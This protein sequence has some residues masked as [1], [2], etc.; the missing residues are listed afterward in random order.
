[1]CTGNVQ[2]TIYVVE[3]KCAGMELA[4]EPAGRQPSATQQR[5]AAA[6]AAALPAE[7]LPA[8][9]DTDP[10]G[11]AAGVGRGS[12]ADGPQ[13]NGAAQEHRQAPQAGG[14]QL[15]SHFSQDMD[16][17]LVHAHSLPLDG[18]LPAAGLSRTK[19]GT[20]P[21][22]AQ[23]QWGQYLSNGEVVT[24]RYSLDDRGRVQKGF[25]DSEGE[26]DGEDGHDR[27]GLLGKAGNGKTD[28]ERPLDSLD[29][30][31]NDGRSA[32]HLNWRISFAC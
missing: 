14:R 22:A 7:G 12:A 5:A 9:A 24:P 31:P 6:A 28:V 10:A 25:D 11:A 26:S 32:G 1:M 30:S 20:L 13:A 27:A 4:A 21:A 8:S 18:T 19:S 17:P 23:Q 15:Y 2:Q 29:A 16:N 3:N